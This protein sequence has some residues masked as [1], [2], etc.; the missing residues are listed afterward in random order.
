MKFAVHDIKPAFFCVIQTVAW[1]SQFAVF[2][3]VPGI[4]IFIIAD[5]I[6]TVVS[7]FSGLDGSV[8]TVG[9]VG[10]EGSVESVG[11][12]GSEGF[13]GTV[14]SV[15]SEGFVGFVGSVGS[16][17][18]VGFVVSVGSSDLI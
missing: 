17:G 16:E 3:N 2:V 8:G 7:G 18:F 6:F 4:G 9:S 1:L 13:V 14:G 15:G 12:V 10:L 11:S 5:P